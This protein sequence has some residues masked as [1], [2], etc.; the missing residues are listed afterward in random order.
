MKAALRR[1]DMDATGS[2]DGDTVLRFGPLE[3]DV[4]GRTVRLDGEEVKT[5]FVEFEI[6]SSLARRPGRA[7]SREMLLVRVWGDASYRDPRTIDVHIR[8]LRE[9]IEPDSR[10]PKYIETVRGV[11]YRFA[12]DAA[13]DS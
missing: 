11:G 2:E 12:R 5:T 13:A 6:L 3:V 9:K 7:L 1:A 10:S 8:H 4:P